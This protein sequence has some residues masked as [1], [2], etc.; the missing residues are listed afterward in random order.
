MHKKKILF[1]DR[2]GTIIEECPRTHQIDSI[3]KVHFLPKVIF[4]LSKIYKELEFELVMVSNQDG[5]G[6]SKFPEQ[7]FWPIHDHIIN[8]MKSEGIQFFSV[9]I[10]QT[11][12]HE[13][14]STRKPGIGMLTSYLTKKYDIE[15]SFV[16]GDRFT[17]ILLAYNLGC[18]SIWIKKDGNRKNEEYFYNGKNLKNIISLITDQWNEIYEYLRFNCS[19]QSFLQR[20]TYETNVKINLSVYGYGKNDI[21]TDIGFF[22]HLLK[23]ISI[24]SSMN[25]NI[26]TIGDLYVDEH[27]TIEDTAITLGKVFCNSLGN[28]RGINR[29]G[30]FILPMDDC[31]STVALDLSGRSDLI[32]NV[33]F[34]RE[35]IGNVP[36]EMFYHFFKSFS[37][38]AKCNLYIKALGNN[39][40]HKIESIFKCFA[41]SIKMAVKKI[42]F[43]K[44]SSSKGLL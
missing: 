14:K 3:E 31:V 26:E 1:I 18:K 16:I 21:K 24:H 23:Q 5:L 42:T 4:F 7:T 36:T 22:D 43:N 28:K 32:W 15:K 10:D 2:D 37:L 11:F 19:G 30:F 17:D 44:I 33:E 39:E 9:H 13:K 6:T 8:I 40:H 34:F 27:H 38:N 29:Y 35:K 25:M 41:R 12:Q 20:K